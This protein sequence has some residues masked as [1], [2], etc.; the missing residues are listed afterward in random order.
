MG[1]PLKGLD[2]FWDEEGLEVFL[3]R[4][5][6]FR[7][8]DSRLRGVAE[9]YPSPMPTFVMPDSLRTRLAVY[10]LSTAE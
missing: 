9:Q 1:P 5:D 10:L 8:G 7:L 4:P 3:A 6:S 2:A